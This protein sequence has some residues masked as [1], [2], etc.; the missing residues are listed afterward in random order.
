MKHITCRKFACDWLSFMKDHASKW[1]WL[2]HVQSIATPCT[3]WFWILVL[4]I[5]PCFLPNPKRKVYFNDIWVKSEP[6]EEVGIVQKVV[7]GLHVT[8]H[9][10]KAY[11]GQSFFSYGRNSFPRAIMMISRKFYFHPNQCLLLLHESYFQN[12][13]IF[14]HKTVMCHV[15]IALIQ[16][17]INRLRRIGLTKIGFP[18][19]LAMKSIY[20]HPWNSFSF[21]DKFINSSHE[22]GTS[23]LLLLFLWTSYNWWKMG[24]GKIQINGVRISWDMVNKFRDFWLRYV[25]NL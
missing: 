24:E 17:P 12:F 5:V 15:V 3:K 22:I 11:C 6:W 25:W 7:E 10:S 16:S 18:A 13:P 20:F 9:F 14:T 1:I 23:L 2:V 4:S 8:E 19:Y 21:S